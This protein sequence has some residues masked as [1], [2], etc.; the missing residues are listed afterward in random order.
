[1]TGGWWRG[2]CS[3]VSRGLTILLEVVGGD[4]KIMARLSDRNIS[5]V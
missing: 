5:V 4:A 1:M 3:A 2:V